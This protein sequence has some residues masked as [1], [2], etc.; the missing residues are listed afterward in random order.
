MSHSDYFAVLEEKFSLIEFQKMPAETF[1]TH[2]FMQEADDVMTKVASD[3]LYE[4]NGNCDAA[5]LR[6]QIKA[7]EDM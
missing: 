7:V 3:I 6:N 1:L 2:L 4:K 5:M